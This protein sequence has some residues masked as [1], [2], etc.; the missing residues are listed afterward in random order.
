MVNF[1]KSEESMNIY[2]DSNGTDIFCTHMSSE[3]GMP[4]KQKLTITCV[5][6]VLSTG[7]SAMIVIF[8]LN[9]CMDNSLHL[10]LWIIN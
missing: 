3:L 4:A 6:S 5:C 1:K 9:L 2:C 8:P 10:R 7:M